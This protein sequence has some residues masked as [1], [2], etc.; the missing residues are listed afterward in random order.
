MIWSH[1]QGVDCDETFSPIVQPAIIP[2]VL[3]L[4]IV[5]QWSIHQLDVKIAFLHGDQHETVFMHQPPGFVDKR[6]HLNVSR[7]CKTLYGLKQ[8][9]HDWYQHFANFLCRLVLLSHKVTPPCPPIGEVL[10]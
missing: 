7:L 9:P 5:R 1:E 6:Y 2:I 10:T 8:A 4:A 3:G